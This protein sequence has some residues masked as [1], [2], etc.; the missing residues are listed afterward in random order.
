M[1]Y[2]QVKIYIKLNNGLNRLLYCSFVRANNKNEALEL[3]QKEFSIPLN[4]NN[5]NI[6]NVLK[7]VSENKRFAQKADISSFYYKEVYLK[8]LKK[9]KNCVLLSNNP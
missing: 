2:Y 6:Y 4:C 1:K 5:S 7:E 8:D 3:H 9:D